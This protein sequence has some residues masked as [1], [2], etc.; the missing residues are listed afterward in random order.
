MSTIYSHVDVYVPGIGLIIDV[1]FDLTLKQAF[2]VGT[3]IV[4]KGSS[5]SLRITPKAFTIACSLF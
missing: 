5:I 3:S 1:L 2:E 4:P